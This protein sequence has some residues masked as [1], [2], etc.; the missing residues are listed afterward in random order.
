MDA[1]DRIATEFN[2][3]LELGHERVPELPSAEQIVWYVVVAR[4]EKD[5]NGFESVFEQG[6]T[7]PEL[8]FLIESLRNLDEENL[9]EEFALVFKLLQQE[10]FYD[11]RNCNML[12]ETAKEQI[13]AIG[14]RVGDR[15]WDFDEKLVALL[16]SAV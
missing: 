12:S 3:L 15:L 1:P 16:D 14:G 13:A 11:Y 2:R 4:C 5:M 8:A 10:H 7:S 9:A 6:L